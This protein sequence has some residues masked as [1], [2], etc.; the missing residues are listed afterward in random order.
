MGWMTYDG[1]TVEFDDRVLAHIQIVIMLRF[2]SGEALTLSWMDSQKV[3]GGRSSMWMSPT[4]PAY[5]KYLGSRPPAI[6]TDW[7]RRLTDSAN[8]SIGLVVTDESGAAIQGIPHT[9]RV[10]T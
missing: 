8:T 6:D 1:L 3:G 5:F 9:N 7:L 10:G 2:R 4:F